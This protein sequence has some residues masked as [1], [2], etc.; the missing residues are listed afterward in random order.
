[1][2]PSHYT[3]PDAKWTSFPHLQKSTK[4]PMQNAKKKRKWPPDRRKEW[5]QRAYRAFS[6]HVFSQN[7]QTDHDLVCGWV[8]RHVKMCTDPS[9]PS[10][11]PP[12]LECKT[13]PWS[14]ILQS[15]SSRNNCVTVYSWKINIILPPW[16]YNVKEN[17]TN[18]CIETKIHAQGVGVGRLVHNFFIFA[19]FTWFV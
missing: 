11:F 5:M 1:M 3:K 17:F 2:I 14:G 10:S 15:P 7:E 13:Q 4:L 9:V 18:Y 19:D 16:V 12:V 6:L 8:E